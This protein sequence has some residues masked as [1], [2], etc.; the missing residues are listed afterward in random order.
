MARVCEKNT[1][2]T[3]IATHDPKFKAKYKGNAEKVVTWLRFV[4]EDVRHHLAKLGVKYIDD[5]VGRTEL[6][7][8]DA[9]FVD[10]IGDRQLDLSAWLSAKQEDSR[11]AEHNSSHAPKLQSPFR[12]EVSEL[13]REIVEDVLG[14]RSAAGFQTLR[15]EIRSTDRAVMATLSGQMA[16]QRSGFLAVD[17][18]QRPIAKQ[19]ENILFEFVGSAGQGFGAF[20]EQG[21][22]VQLKGEAN[23]AVAKSIC[24]GELVVVPASEC[25]LE[26]PARHAIVGNC[27]L[28]G[29]TSG[30]V[31]VYGKAGDRFAVR[32]SG[33][34]AVVEGVGLHAC[35]YMT[36]G[37]VL[38]LGE[39]GPNIGAG[40]TG[41]RVYLRRD[42]TK[43][44]HS[45][46]LEVQDLSGEDLA[47]VMRLISEHHHRTRSE[48][49][50]YYLKNPKKIA[51][52]F[53][54]G[55]LKS[56][57]IEGKVP[58]KNAN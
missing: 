1:C 23:D 56:R 54:L 46:F 45:G 41:G 19:V 3:G 40:M 7:R 49:A 2:P 38:I 4:A 42:D 51:S 18:G 11:L 10:L 33:A 15:Y 17:R 5:I 6:L 22:R 48:T 26:H 29:A 13:N 21:L 30:Q 36:R 44:L 47:V 58:F 28:Y 34:I 20:L 8:R 25:K 52:D 24:G 14:L 37:Q 12:A 55:A 39:A 53:I 27:A 32:N 57:Q 16:A 9:R 43:H 35:E 31:F 50:E